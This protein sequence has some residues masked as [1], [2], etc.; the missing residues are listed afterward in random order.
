MFGSNHSKD[1]IK[2]YHTFSTPCMCKRTCYLLSNINNYFLG[3]L[4]LI[5]FIYRDGTIAYCKYIK[6]ERAQSFDNKED[7]T[8]T[9]T[10]AAFSIQQ[11]TRLCK[12][13]PHWHLNVLFKT[14]TCILLFFSFLVLLRHGFFFFHFYCFV[15]FII[16]IVSSVFY[17]LFVL[18]LLLTHRGKKQYFDCP[19]LFWTFSVDIISTLTTSK[20][21]LTSLFLFFFMIM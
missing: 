11:S 9:R 17:F 14:V 8:K 21:C 16:L 1:K 5:P 12:M 19:V 10:A 3:V 4:I 6:W 20:S 2:R 7:K 13:P 15:P 18:L